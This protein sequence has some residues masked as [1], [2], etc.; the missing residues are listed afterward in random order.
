MQVLETFFGTVDED[1]IRN[2]FV[3]IYELLDGTH[4]ACQLRC[5]EGTLQ[6]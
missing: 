1:S 3:V 6:K 2:N 4:T 5:S